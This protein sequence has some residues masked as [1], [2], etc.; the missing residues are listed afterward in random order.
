MVEVVR[1][2]VEEAA[3]DGSGPMD[4]LSK[5]KEERKAAKAKSLETTR[6]VKAYSKRVAR[7]QARAA[8]LSDD[9]LLLEC[10]R[11]LAAKDRQRQ[12]FCDRENP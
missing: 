11:R 5:L 8:E 1:K 2:S 10:A 4:T 9:G 7:L 3:S 12:L 6:E